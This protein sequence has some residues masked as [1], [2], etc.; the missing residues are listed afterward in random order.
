MLRT[1]KSIDL[2]VPRI[3]KPFSL[4]SLLSARIY[5]ILTVREIKLMAVL[6]NHKT[7][8][9]LVCTYIP[10]GLHESSVGSVFHS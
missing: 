8:E 2:L 6:M 9:T 1:L 4:Y 3:E 10:T 5:S 7:H